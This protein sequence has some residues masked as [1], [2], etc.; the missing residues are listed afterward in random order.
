MRH[1]VTI[2]LFIG[3]F[4][5][6]SAQ[7]EFSYRNNF[8]NPDSDSYLEIGKEENNVWQIG[9]PSKDFFSGNEYVI[10]PSIMTD[11]INSYPINNSSSFEISFGNETL[12]YIYH[13]F[14][15]SFQHKVQTNSGH[16]GGI[17]E[18]SYDDGTN[19][20]NIISDS[21]KKR[22]HGPLPPI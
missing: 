17:V 3:I 10:P 21:A 5:H 9:F 18:I 1:L 11:T 14:V 2:M 12:K 13:F 6:A 8:N 16:D 4:V 15:I 19:W 22:L 7:N 20:T